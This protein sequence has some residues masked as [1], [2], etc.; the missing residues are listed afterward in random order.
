M[1]Q[2]VVK[3]LEVE[4]LFAR[5]ERDG[6]LGALA[7]EVKVPEE[8]RV[9]L[10]VVEGAPRERAFA[11][12]YARDG[13]WELGDVGVRDHAADVVAHDV[14]GRRDVEVG[15]EEGVNV[16]GQRALGKVARQGRTRGVAVAAVVWRDDVVARFG[17]GGDHVSELVGCFGEAVDEED[18]GLGRGV[19]GFGFNVEEADLAVRG[20]LE[21]YL[22]VLDL[23]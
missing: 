14:Y 23:D 8:L 17:K 19:L 7:V 3:V 1:A 2:P 11:P 15:G 6:Q 5:D 18:R 13:G 20:G 10:G 16:R 4:P 12:C 21:G 22:V 9:F